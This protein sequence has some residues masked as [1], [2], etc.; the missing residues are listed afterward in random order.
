MHKILTVGIIVSGENRP[1]SGNTCYGKVSLSHRKGLS[2]AGIAARMVAR[3]FVH[4]SIHHN[5][6]A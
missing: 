5:R 3:L 1:E 2:E 4:S 6:K